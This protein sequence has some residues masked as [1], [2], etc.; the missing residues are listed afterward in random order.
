MLMTI[1]KGL[2]YWTLV[3]IIVT[4]TICA[5]LFG[6]CGWVGLA[7]QAGRKCARLTYSAYRRVVG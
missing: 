6:G 5:I 1:M 4:P 7:E 3:S 2:M